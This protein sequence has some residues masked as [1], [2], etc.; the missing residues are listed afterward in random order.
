MGRSS[1]FLLSGCAV[2]FL[3]GVIVLLLYTKYGLEQ[4]TL[5]KTGLWLE[6][7]VVDFVNK[8]G[9]WPSNAEEIKAFVREEAQ[10][11]G[12][13]QSPDW[14]WWFENLDRY[15]VTWTYAIE[16]GGSVQIEVTFQH[17]GPF[18]WFTSRAYWSVPRYRFGSDTPPP[19]EATGSRR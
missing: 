5:Y 7:V 11:G 15:S 13:Y 6:D 9:A 10:A 12:K 16:P 18:G 14:D 4:A 3:V 17:T 8:N 1:K 2:A 19:P